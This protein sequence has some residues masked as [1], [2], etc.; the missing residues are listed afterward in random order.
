[1]IKR[2]WLI[3]TLVLFL[4]LLALS[5]FAVNIDS[6]VLQQ[7]ENNP[8]VSVIVV[9]KDQPTSAKA[10]GISS[11]T[12]A[13]KIM[14]TDVQKKVLDGLRVRERKTGDLGIAET[15]DYDLDLHHQY[16]I[17]NGFSGEITE[18]G[19]EKLKNNPNIKKIYFNRILHPT[20]TGSIPQIHADD[21]WNITANNQKI[22]G[23]GETICITDTGID[24][25]HTAFTERIVGQYCYCQ[26]SNY[27][28]GG[29][30]PDNTTEDISAEDGQGHGTHVAGIAASGNGTYRGVAP[31]AGIVAIK[32]CD[33][34]AQ[35]SCSTADVIAGIQWCINNATVYNISVISISLG[36]GG[37]YNSYCNDDAI[38][39]VIN[40]AVGQNISLVIAS[41]NTGWTNG[42]TSPACVQNA[43]PV[44]GVN[45][46]DAIF[47]NR[48]NILSILA[49]GVSITSPYLGGGVTALSG[50][51]MATP[52]VSGAAALMHQY[53]RLAY[54]QIITPQQIENKFIL[55]GKNIDDTANSGKNY[56]RID[57]LKAIQ[58]Y[59]NFTSNNPANATTISTNWK[60]I[61]ITSD[62]SL[63][64]AL[65]EW[66]YLNGTATNYSMNQTTTT[67]FYYNITG[68]TAINYTYKVY[69]NDSANT[70]GTSETRFIIVD[71]TSPNITIYSPINNSYLRQAFNL[72]ISI[73]NS[74]ISVSNYSITNFTGQVLQSN[75]STSINS[76]AFNWFDLV[77]ISSST[78]IDG[79]Y[80][81]SVFANDSLSN[82]ATGSANFIVDKTLPSFIN[83]TRNPET[84]YNNDTVVFTVNISEAYLNTSSVYLESNFSGIWTNYSLIQENGNRFNYSLTG[85]TNLTNQKNITYRFHAQDLAGNQN[86]SD[87]Y[88][89]IVQNRPISFLNITFPANGMVL[90][91]GN[92]TAFNSTATDP[93][94][95]TLT[96][97][98]NFSDGT[99]LS[100]GQNVVHAFNS[101]GTFV[102]VLNVSDIL[103]SNLTNITIIVNDTLPPSVS[104][105]TYDSELHL[106]QNGN[107]LSITANV[108][109][110]SG[111]FNVTTS[112]N[113]TLQNGYC[114][115]TSTTWTCNWN[116]TDFA[117]IGSYN[118]TL[119]YTDNFVNRH[120]NFT[121]YSFTVTSCSD[122]TQNGDETGADCGGSCTACSGS[123]SSGSSSSSGG[124]GSSSGGG[125]S[126]SS[127]SGGLG[128]TSTQA[129]KPAETP[130]P[131]TTAPG[132]A[133]TTA[134]VP[135]PAAP[136]VLPNI[137][138]QRL[139]LKE[140]EKSVVSIDSSEISI[141][142]LELDSKVSKEVEVKVVSFKEKPAEVPELENTYQY[143]KMDLDLSAEDIKSAKIYFTLP[144]EWL[145][146]HNYS[147]DSVRLYAL[148]GGD[149]KK[150]DTVLVSKENALVYS[151]D[152]KTFNYFAITAEEAGGKWWPGL[153]LSGLGAKGWLLLGLGIF[154]TILLV[155]YLAVSWREGKEE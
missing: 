130:K 152:A 54:S 50:T 10:I 32:V 24:T 96:Y 148:I 16:S 18:E 40:S 3:G 60:I 94:G 46:A 30:C 19:L 76:A 71:Q 81:L 66:G 133:T 103:S 138:S 1:M 117:S 106:Q 114:T 73:V 128:T 14:R 155:I 132:G 122:G 4:S 42:I 95:D 88:S 26:V 56:S 63:S 21:V 15:S 119:N 154:I 61:N 47:Y 144:A 129:E 55:T 111:I 139:E 48:G 75:S 49:P 70:F 107:D 110:Y 118:F 53:W 97:R 20:L 64:S 131:A 113:S 69:G 33:N 44:G 112:F 67:N 150:L 7:L 135:E 84:V 39:P 86:N 91:V 116:L 82:S 83:Q 5:V 137:F 98:W 104:S 2:G 43:T 136:A 9:L 31:G 34:A 23:T 125:G 99:A 59:L 145:S 109:D 147:E 93:D 58:P 126:S 77:N 36:G 85:T 62:V 22:N 6:E 101:T 115:N 45:S 127:S 79:N 41:G 87:T 29:C 25:D 134:E 17:I 146:L 153:S 140:K 38:A 35:A 124:G 12:E 90:E 143:L 51:S 108:F 92:S 8:E 80:T 11:V 52:H 28:A 68:L 72:N 102:V 120:N 57:I 65:L 142:K 105:M 13:R 78:F 121:H 149:W 27:G 100:S 151:A 89:F 123:S 141:T 74:L 37:P